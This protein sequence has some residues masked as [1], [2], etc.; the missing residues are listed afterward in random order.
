MHNKLSI[1]FL[2]AFAATIC[3][4]ADEDPYLWLQEVEGEKA[5]E[6]DFHT[7]FRAGGRDPQV[8]RHSRPS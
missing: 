7:C 2:I 8:E 4:A 6:E 5:S 3:V 1:A